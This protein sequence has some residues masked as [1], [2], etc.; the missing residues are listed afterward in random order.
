MNKDKKEKWEVAGFCE[1]NEYEYD[2]LINSKR[3]LEEC[4]LETKI[5]QSSYGYVLYVR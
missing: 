5:E 3:D 4:E 1:N 2:M